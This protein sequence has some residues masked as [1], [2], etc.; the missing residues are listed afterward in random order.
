MA[1]DNYYMKILKTFTRYTKLH[2]HSVTTPSQE[3][4]Q[5]RLTGLISVFCFI[6]VCQTNGSSYAYLKQ[7]K[8]TTSQTPTNFP[9]TAN[10]PKRLLYCPVPVAV[11]SK[12]CVF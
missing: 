8:I 7:Y 5:R 2:F 4:P 3:M 10:Y 6:D 1:V 9:L 11:Q 12:A